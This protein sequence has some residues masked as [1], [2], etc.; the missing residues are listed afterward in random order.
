MPERFKVVFIMQGAT[1][2]LGFFYPDLREDGA[3]ILHWTKGQRNLTK[4]SKTLPFIAQ[5]C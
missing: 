2:V 4:S 5:L 1:Q 3:V